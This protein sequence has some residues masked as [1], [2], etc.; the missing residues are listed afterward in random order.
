MRTPTPGVIALQDVT[1]IFYKMD[2]F[3]H[4]HKEFVDDLEDKLR[5]WSDEQQIAEPV[6]KLVS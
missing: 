6:K 5:H 1:T 3:H 4:I 2:D